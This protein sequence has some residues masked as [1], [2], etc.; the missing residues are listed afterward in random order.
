MSADY[1]FVSRWTVARSRES[2]WD[3]LED[4]LATDDPM[5]WW[6]AVQVQ[7]YDGTSMTVR[8]ASAFGYALTFSMTDLDVRRPDRLTF[9]AN[10]DL[11][12]SGAVTFVDA[13]ATSCVMEIDWR[14]VTDRRWMRLTGWFLRPIFRAGHTL[15]MRQGEKHLNTW[16]AKARPIR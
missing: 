8:A 14:V 1:A 12:G 5:P 11:R 4:L 13:D 16:L 2:L 10:G 7:S 3:V 9:Q 15:I 6:P